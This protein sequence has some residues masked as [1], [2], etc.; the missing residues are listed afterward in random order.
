MIIFSIYMFIC[1]FVRTI[2]FNIYIYYGVL[3]LIYSAIN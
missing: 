3:F 2:I 1:L